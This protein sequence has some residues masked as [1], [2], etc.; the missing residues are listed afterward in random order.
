MRIRQPDM[1][2]VSDDYGRAYPIFKGAPFWF[3]SKNRSYREACTTWVESLHDFFVSHDLYASGH[4]EF[5]GVETFVLKR[6]ELT[7]KGLLFAWRY[8]DGYL[9]HLD[10]T[11]RAD[12]PEYLEACLHHLESN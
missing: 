5:N 2:P 7:P 10:R 9:E 4:S 3:A 12:H 6:D 1:G 11:G 8:L